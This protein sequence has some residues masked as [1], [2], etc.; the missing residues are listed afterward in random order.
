MIS[1]LIETSNWFSI[2]ILL[3]SDP[4][5]SQSFL[6]VSNGGSVIAPFFTVL[7][8]HWRFDKEKLG[9]AEIYYH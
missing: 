8:G 7:D 4:L 5:F 1:W 2:E 9:H 3:E 6:A